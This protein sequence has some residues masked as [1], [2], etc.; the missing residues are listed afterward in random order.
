[1]KNSD[2]VVPLPIN[3]ELARRIA[4]ARL[5]REKLLTDFDLSRQQ[6][7]SARRMEELAQGK[8]LD[9]SEN[10]VIFGVP[11]SGKTHLAAALGLHWCLSGRSV[12][13]SKATALAESVTTYRIKDLDRFEALIVDDFSGAFHN[14]NCEALLDLFEHRCQRRSVI[15]T[16]TIDFHKWDALLKYK[17]GAVLDRVLQRCNIIQL[18]RHSCSYRPF[19]PQQ[20]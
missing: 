19:R 16:S 11:G 2:L 18:D 8:F 6:S 1:M 14:E 15:F 17:S 5:P 10:L 4:R 20:Q 9:R 7:F 12:R 13:F 3:E